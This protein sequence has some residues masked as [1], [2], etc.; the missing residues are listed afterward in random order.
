[1][2]PGRPDSIPSSMISFPASGTAADAMT[3]IPRSPGFPD[4]VQGSPV[5]ED[6]QSSTVFLVPGRMMQSNLSRGTRHHV[7]HGDLA[8][9]PR[10][11]EVGEVGRRRMA[12]L[13]RNRPVVSCP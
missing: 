13:D 1:V 4:L 6:L 2:T 11:R 3:G 12:D 8:P 5:T 7:L 10:N 9:V